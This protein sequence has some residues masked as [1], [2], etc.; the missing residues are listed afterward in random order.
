MLPGSEKMLISTIRHVAEPPPPTGG[1][2]PAMWLVGESR[3]RFLK[4]CRQRRTTIVPTAGAKHWQAS[5]TAVRNGGR[6]TYMRAARRPDAAVRAATTQRAV[7]SPYTTASRRWAPVGGAHQ[8]Q[9][10]EALVCET[11]REGSSSGGG[12]MGR[13]GELSRPPPVRNCEMWERERVSETTAKTLQYR[14]DGPEDAPVLILGSS[15]G[16]TWHMS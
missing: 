8:R 15:L 11:E 16:T 6:S 2:P 10:H 12:Y 1:E 4:I 3:A 7:V 13:S 9:D 14:F 5:S